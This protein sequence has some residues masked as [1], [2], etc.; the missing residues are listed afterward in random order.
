MCFILWMLIGNFAFAVFRYFVV[1]S[2]FDYVLFF[3]YC[4][5]SD[6]SVFM[7]V[8]NVCVL[9]VCVCV[10]RLVFRSLVF[11]FWYEVIGICGVVVG[12][13]LVLCD[14]VCCFVCVVVFCVCFGVVCVLVLVRCVV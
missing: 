12:L 7:N 13:M 2:V 5:C 14:V 10:M 1:V 6:F 4:F 3:V 9:Y 8:L 11:V